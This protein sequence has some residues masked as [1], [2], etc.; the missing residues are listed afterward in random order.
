[1]SKHSVWT[2]YLSTKKKSWTSKMQ[3]KWRCAKGWAT[4]YFR[5][6]IT[7]NFIRT[8]RQQCILRNFWHKLQKVK[9]K[10]KCLSK[11][12]KGHG[13]RL[14]DWMFGTFWHKNSNSY[15]NEEPTWSTFYSNKILFYI[16]ISSFMFKSMHHFHPAAQLRNFHLAIC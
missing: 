11:P 7:W 16:C 4:R 10:V 15:L 9:D 3:D 12:S 14:M 8:V 1:M 2:E 6:T 5:F 13:T